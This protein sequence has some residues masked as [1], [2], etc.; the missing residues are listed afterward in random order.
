MEILLYFKLL[1]TDPRF[2]A[3]NIYQKSMLVSS[4]G[5]QF[6]AKM[7]LGKNLYDKALLYTNP[8]LWIKEKE[9]TGKLPKGRYQKV[10]SEFKKI[11]E[12]GRVTGKMLESSE[13]SKALKLLHTMRQS[14]KP[15]ERIFLQGDI[16]N[17]QETNPLKILSEE[18]DELG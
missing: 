18:S 3:L 13:I 8:E 11:Q 7:E 15:S 10:N 5:A 6:E 14:V 12:Y 17:P 4:I 16:N 2:Q 9:R 1:P